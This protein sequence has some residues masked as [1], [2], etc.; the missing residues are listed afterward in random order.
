MTTV[1][2]EPRAAARRPAWIDAR[3]MWA[4]LAISLIW[5][6][7]LFDAVFGPDIKSVD[8]GGDAA[9]VPSAVAVALFAVLAT[10]AV[11]KYGFDRTKKS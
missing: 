8:A 7:V 6:A 4:S 3:D 9:V 11:A 1:T 2:H 5:L 10:F